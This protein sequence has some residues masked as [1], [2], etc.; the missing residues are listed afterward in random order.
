MLPA[1]A[2]VKFNFLAKQPILISIL[3]CQMFPQIVFVIPFFMIL[4]KVG[5]IDTFIGVIISYLPFTT[6]IGVWLTR[7]FFAE[8]PV[9]IEEAAMI[10][11]CSRFQ[12]FYKIALPIALPGIA[13][14]GIYAFLFAWSELMFSRSYLSTMS[15]Q[16]IPVFLSLFVGQYQTRWGPLFAGSVVASIPPI[17]VFGFL[18]KYFIR[19]LTSGSVKG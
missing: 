1:Y 17:I 16:T 19:G 14:V 7:N 18:Q 8:V 4:S 2:T 5:L 11:G 6:P 12:T 9:D 15:L 3:I 10:D 13:A